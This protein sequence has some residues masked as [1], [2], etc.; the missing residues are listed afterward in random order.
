MIG[1]SKP[2]EELIGYFD[3]WDP[4]TYGGE[5]YN[6]D[7]EST[8]AAVERGEEIFWY[9]CVGPRAPYANVYNDHP[10]T[11][12]RALWW[13]AWKY[14]I[15][16]F[17]YWWFNYWRP[18]IALSE[19]SFPWPLSQLRSWNSRSYKW[20]NGDG[21]LVYPGRAGKAL[22][23]IRLSV[24]RDAIEDWEVLFMLRRAVELAR[25]LNSP[26]AESFLEPADKLLSVP[27]QIT[28]SLT[29]WS[30]EPATYLAARD[31]LY[32][33]LS[34]LRS[35]IGEDQVDRYTE[36]WVKQHQAWLQRKF[37]ER[38]AATR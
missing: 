22:A 14:E 24:M 1:G 2:R 28:S 37:E 12:I 29:E 8:R 34:G 23:S 5:I 3:V 4:I 36:S 20:S 11:A 21:V 33:L 19:G 7:P 13:Q 9:T 6:F 18:N 30:Q 31:E 38:V 32:R 26:K 15:T 16:G 35:A 27:D 10:L 17:E 25:K